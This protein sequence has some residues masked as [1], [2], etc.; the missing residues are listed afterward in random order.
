MRYGR[1][2][3]GT[4]THVMRPGLI[5]TVC[6]VWLDEISDRPPHPVMCKTCERRIAAEVLFAAEVQQ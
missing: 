1:L 3:R 2:P 6:G 4:V 5:V